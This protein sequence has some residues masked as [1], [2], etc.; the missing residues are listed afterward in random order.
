MEIIG[1]FLRAELGPQRIYLFWVGTGTK[2][3]PEDQEAD[4]IAILYIPVK[5]DQSC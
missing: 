1:R 3:T 5:V 4:N 2:E